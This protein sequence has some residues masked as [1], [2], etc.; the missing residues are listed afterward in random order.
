M[1]YILN[2]QCG[3]DLDLTMSDIEAIFICYNGFISIIFLTIVKKDRHV[4]RLKL[5]WTVEMMLCIYK[6][7]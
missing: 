1:G 3:L 7:E 2:S 6:R 5:V 4:L